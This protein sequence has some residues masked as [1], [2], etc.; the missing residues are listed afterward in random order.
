MT[1]LAKAHDLRAAPWAGSPGCAVPCRWAS[2][3]IV[4]LRGTATSRG[5]DS[6]VATHGRERPRRPASSHSHPSPSALLAP[7][8]EGRRLFMAASP[9][10]TVVSGYMN[11]ICL[12]A[13]GSVKWLW[14]NDRDRRDTA[15]AGGP[16][17]AASAGSARIACTGTAYPEGSYA[18]PVE[19]ARGCVWAPA[20]PA[21][22]GRC[23]RR[24]GGATRATSASG[25]SCASA[26]P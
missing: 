14:G 3:P 21:P 2:P 5:G 6:R 10:A 13:G 23:Y 16:A 26:V 22:S 15:W 17:A 24:G 20:P 18:R 11:Q 7:G 12:P 8:R 1:R 9:L 4:P 25:G 19:I